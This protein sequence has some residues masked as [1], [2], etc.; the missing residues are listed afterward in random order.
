MRVTVRIEGPD[1]VRE[2]DVFVTRTEDTVELE[3]DG[4]RFEA[5]LARE[6]ETTDVQLEDEDIQVQIPDDHVALVDGDRTRF[7]V[8]SFRPG[9]APGEHETLVEGEGRILAPMPGTLVEVHVEEGDQVDAEDPLATLEAMKMQST[10]EASRSGTVLRVHAG[11]GD[12][13]EGDAVLFEIGS[14]E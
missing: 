2:H 1:R 4:E 13:V 7:W 11:E 8:P 9:G 12:A 5:Q 6:D 10:I 14:E 3:V